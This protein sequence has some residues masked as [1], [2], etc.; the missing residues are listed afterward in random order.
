MGESPYASDQAFNYPQM[1]DSVGRSEKKKVE[2]DALVL[3]EG[4]VGSP[5]DL[6]NGA[7]AVIEWLGAT[8]MEV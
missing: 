6:C 3:E 2:S 1:F 4:S 7:G 8:G 5:H